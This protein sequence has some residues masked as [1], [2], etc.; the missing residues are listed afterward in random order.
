MLEPILRDTA[1]LH[2]GSLLG[3]RLLDPLIDELLHEHAARPFPEQI[4]H[5]GPGDEGVLDAISYASTLVGHRAERLSQA[6]DLS[7]AAL[8][9]LEH[10]SVQL[11]AVAA[12][13]LLELALVSQQLQVVLDRDWGQAHG[14]AERV[15]AVVKDASDPLWQILWRTRVGTRVPAALDAGWPSAISVMTQLQKFAKGH[16]ELSA[17]LEYI[18]GS[19]CE[20]THPNVEAQATMWRLAPADSRGRRRV[21]FDP[22][23]S[24]SPTKL[25]VAESVRLALIVIVNLA[26]DLWW[27]AAEVACVANFKRT[28]DN[29]ALGL[30]IPASAGHPCCCGA[31]LPGANCDHPQPPAVSATLRLG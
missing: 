12:R 10:G 3:L 21:L 24:E 2:P 14:H 17:K 5:V 29:L 9:S 6:V 7:A 16:E 22:S 28:R 11:A 8:D 27:V 23:R 1:D 19:L 30:P 20:A 15:T 18:Y 26:R 31:G 4:V 13:T 25:I